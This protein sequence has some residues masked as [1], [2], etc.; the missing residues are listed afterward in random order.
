LFACEFAYA[1]ALLS[2]INHFVLKYFY[3]GSGFI[4]PYHGSGFTYRRASKPF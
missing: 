4:T 3:E 2:K 1:I